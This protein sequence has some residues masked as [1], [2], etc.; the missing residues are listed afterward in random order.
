MPDITRADVGSRVGYFNAL[1]IPLCRSVIIG[2][3]FNVL[4]QNCGDLAGYAENTLAVGAVCGNAYIEYIV[5]QTN[6]SFYVFA[7]F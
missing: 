3:F 1:V 7:V 2:G 5:V 6:D 4:L